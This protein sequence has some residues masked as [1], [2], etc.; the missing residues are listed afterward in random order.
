MLSVVF[1]K[2]RANSIVRDRQA[3]N[4]QE[5]EVANS[6]LGSFLVKLLQGGSDVLSSLYVTEAHLVPPRL[7]L[8]HWQTQ[9]AGTAER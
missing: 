3:H 9:K 7:P 2:Y 1:K 5:K 6:S 4:R 8:R